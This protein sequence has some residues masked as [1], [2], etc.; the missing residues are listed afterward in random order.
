MFDRTHWMAL[1]LLT[2]VSC[3]GTGEPEPELDKTTSEAVSMSVLERTREPLLV[4]DRPWEA[5]TLNYLTVIKE[6]PLWRMWYAAYDPD[7]EYDCDAY[8]CY[9]VSQ[10]GVQW[11]KPELDLVPWKDRLKT[12]ILMDGPAMRANAT[13]VFRDDGAPSGERYKALLQKFLGRDENGRGVWQ[14]YAAVSSDGLKWDL[15]SQSIYPWNSD[16]QN[17]CFRDGNRYRFYVRLWRGVDEAGNPFV[18]TETR[19]ATT[20]TIG[21]SE[22]TEFSRLSQSSGDPGPEARRSG[23]HGLLQQRLQPNKGRPLR[24]VHLRVLQTG[25]GH[26]GTWCLEPGRSLLSAPIERAAAGPGQRVRLQAPLR[27]TWSHSG[28]AARYLLVLL[29]GSVHQARQQCARK[30]PPRGRRRK[31]PGPD[32]GSGCLMR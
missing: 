12:N 19:N 9:A 20:R 4:S 16:T 5:F 13:T 14:N 3:R 21:L 10:D 7:Y 15:L 24:H 22:S 11:E 8:L 27:G 29:P 26:A 30:G 23:R 18:S 32:S 31:V 25:R 6:G 17:V 28:T 1:L 2:L